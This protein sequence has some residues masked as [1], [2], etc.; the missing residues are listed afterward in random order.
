[1]TNELHKIDP[2]DETTF[3]TNEYPDGFSKV[4]YSPANKGEAV[5]STLTVPDNFYT[6]MYNLRAIRDLDLHRVVPPGE[7]TQL[8]VDNVLMMSDTP[9]EAWE[10]EDAYKR[11]TGHVLVN[12]LG[13]GMFVHAILKKPEVTQV[14]VVEKSQ[15]V[16]DI[17]WPS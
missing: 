8:H 10:H 1:M 3:M 2:A 5:L 17:V 16:V 11:A 7:Y 12:G 14:T 13:L 15:D 6:Q 9:A 4:E